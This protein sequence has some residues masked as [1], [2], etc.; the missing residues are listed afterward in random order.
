LGHYIKTSVENGSLQGLA[1]HG[2]QPATSHSQF[3]DDTI[4]MNIPM[5]Q[6]SSKRNSILSDFSEATGTSFNLAKSHLFF[7]NTPKY[8]QQHVSQHS[9]HWSTT[10]QLTT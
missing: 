7:F 9:P 4:L 8:I 10:Y 3:V 5:A 1:L 2:L 6:E